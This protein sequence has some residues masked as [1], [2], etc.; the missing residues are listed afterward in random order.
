M[1]LNHNSHLAPQFH[2]NTAVED[3]DCDMTLYHPNKHMSFH[4]TI[5]KTQVLSTYM[6]SER[7]CTIMVTM[8]QSHQNKTH[9][10]R[11]H[12]VFTNKILQ[13]YAIKKNTMRTQTLWRWRWTMVNVTSALPDWQLFFY[14][15]G[16]LFR[17]RI[18]VKKHAFLW[19]S[20]FSTQLAFTNIYS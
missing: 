6:S 14:C 19:I 4:K 3:D 9:F 1:Y 18:W 2:N 16:H 8:P 10:H 15:Q 17:R 20:S 13:F 7:K 5:F 12:S 11:H